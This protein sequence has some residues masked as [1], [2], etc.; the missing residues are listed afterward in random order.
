M[1][2]NA[3]STTSNPEQLQ[4]KIPTGLESEKIF[5]LLDAWLKACAN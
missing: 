5:D 2:S 1:N 4:T 3:A